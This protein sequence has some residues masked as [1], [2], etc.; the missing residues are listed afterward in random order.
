MTRLETLHTALIATLTAAS[1]TSFFH[2]IWMRG[3]KQ[4]VADAQ[5]AAAHGEVAAEIIA[6]L[7][8]HK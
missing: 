6:Q 2:W 7:G 4:G 3:Y 8:D 5:R 1:L